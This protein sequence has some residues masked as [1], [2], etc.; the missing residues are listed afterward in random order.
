MV[1]KCINCHKEIIGFNCDCDRDEKLWNRGDRKND[2]K[3]KKEK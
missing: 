1:Y 2:N 3:N